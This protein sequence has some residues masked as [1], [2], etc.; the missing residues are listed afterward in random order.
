MPYI[1]Y[2]LLVKQGVYEGVL[3]YM[4]TKLSECP[5]CHSNEGFFEKLAVSGSTR[6]FYSYD[7]SEADNG[8]MYDSL[9]IKQSQYAYCICCNRRIGILNDIL[10]E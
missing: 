7:G 3:I 2:I 8:G 9:T 5:H 1:A 6:Y 4:K 10:K